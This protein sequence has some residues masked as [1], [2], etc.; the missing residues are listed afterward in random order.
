VTPGFRLSHARLNIHTHSAGYIAGLVVDG[1][2]CGRSRIKSSA[3]GGI[4]ATQAVIDLCAAHNIKPEMRVIPVEEI[5]RA[6]EALDT[7]NESGERFVIDIAGSLDE[8]AFTR[9]ADV[10]PPRLGHSPGGIGV[11]AILGAISSLFC[12]CRY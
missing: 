4:E 11:C 1:L 5:N 12:C 10:A 7:A 6:F 3:I 9:C 8:A 2:V